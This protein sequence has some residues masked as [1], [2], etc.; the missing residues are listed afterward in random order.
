MKR[1]IR[2]L[3]AS[4]LALAMVVGML[5]MTVFAV[6]NTGTFT[7]ITTQEELTTGQYVMVVD[8]GY[9]VGALDGTWLT[10]TQL[11]E[12]NGTIT[13]P[14]RISSE[15]IKILLLKSKIILATSPFTS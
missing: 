1:R 5:P 15:P 4:L 7:K 10:A 8:T 2:N 3:L 13:A 14:L 12:E 9:A 11:T 6:E